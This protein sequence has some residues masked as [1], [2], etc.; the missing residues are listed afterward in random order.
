MPDHPSVRFCTDRGKADASYTCFIKI[1][2]VIGEKKNIAFNPGFDFA[3]FNPARNNRISG[4]LK[5]L[6]KEP[7]FIGAD[8]M[9]LNV[10]V[11]C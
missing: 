9:V 3:P 10:A 2:P 11:G 7:R 5:K 4:I 8:K 6:Q 1:H